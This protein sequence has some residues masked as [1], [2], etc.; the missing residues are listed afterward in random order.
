MEG[1][2]HDAGAWGGTRLDVRERPLGAV[3]HIGLFEK[4]IHVRGDVER[5]QRD[6]AGRHLLVD[7]YI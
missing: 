2:A 6:A 4:D 3:D 1:R 7:M 5:R